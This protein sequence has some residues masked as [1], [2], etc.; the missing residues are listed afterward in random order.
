M[1]TMGREVRAH[2]RLHSPATVLRVRAIDSAMGD[3]RRHGQLSLAEFDPVSAVGYIQPQRHTLRIKLPEAQRS[4]IRLYPVAMASRA[5]MGG[6]VPWHHPFRN[7]VAP[8][9]VSIAALPRIAQRTQAGRHL[10][11]PPHM[12]GG[13]F[14]RRRCQRQHQ[15]ILLHRAFHRNPAAAPLPPLACSGI[16]PVGNVR[17]KPAYTVTPSGTRSKSRNEGP[18]CARLVSLAATTV[19]PPTEAALC[20]KNDRRVIAISYRSFVMIATRT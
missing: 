8:A 9:Q 6:E 2:M 16:P 5:I 10:R 14:G 11:L 13:D 1:G 4:R 15:R 3:D 12:H 20:R 17:S 7:Q 18:F 19:K